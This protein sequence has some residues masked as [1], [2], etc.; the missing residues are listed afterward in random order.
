MIFHSMDPAVP[1]LEGGVTGLGRQTWS[2]DGNQVKPDVTMSL[3]A[4]YPSGGME[5]NFALRWFRDVYSL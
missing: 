3:T 4:E 2:Q 1:K 5:K